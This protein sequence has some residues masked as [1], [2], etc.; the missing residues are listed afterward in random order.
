MEKVTPDNTKVNRISVK[1]W[2][3]DL[4]V[5]KT[6][7][8][9]KVAGNIVSTRVS[10]IL[11]KG[12]RGYHSSIRPLNPSTSSLLAP[13]IATIDIETICGPGDTQ[14]PGFLSRLTSGY[15]LY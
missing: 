12:S 15:H 9:T 4:Y 13:D 10:S 8:I 11:P 7:K 6:V 5:N 2:S 3:M 1:V 14:I